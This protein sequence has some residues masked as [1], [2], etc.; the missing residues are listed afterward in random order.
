M[1]PDG[2][3]VCAGSSNEILF[4]VSTTGGEVW[5]NTGGSGTGRQYFA[6][7][8]MDGNGLIGLPVFGSGPAIDPRPHWRSYDGATGTEQ[9]TNLAMGTPD[10]LYGGVFMPSGYFYFPSNNTLRSVKVSDG[11]AH[12]QFEGLVDMSGAPARDDNG[13]FLFFSEDQ[14]G[15]FSG[16]ASFHCN[17]F[18]D[19]FPPT[20]APVWS[21]SMDTVSITCKP[22]VDGAYSIFLTDDTGRII[23]I[24]WDRDMPLGEDNPQ[25][26]VSQQ[27]T[28]FRFSSFAIGNGAAYVISEDNDLYMVGTPRL[29]D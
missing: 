29:P 7:I 18:N 2:T 13:E 8:A 23:M 12:D 22:A 24:S 3:L 16:F 26:T 25:M 9:Q 17:S 11:T 10:N 21:M 19:D 27:D 14:G 6:D 28:S 1:H 20:Q 5:T 4:G 15:G